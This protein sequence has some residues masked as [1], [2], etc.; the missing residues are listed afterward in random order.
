MEVRGPV[1][2]AAFTKKLGLL[3]RTFRDVY[4]GFEEVRL[5]LSFEDWIRVSQM[6]RRKVT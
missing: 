4:P 3:A 2:P 1:L 6:Q 5:G